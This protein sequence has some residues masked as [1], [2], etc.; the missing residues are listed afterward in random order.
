[1]EKLVY[2]K[3][4]YKHTAGDILVAFS[5]K[6]GYSPLI[7]HQNLTTGC[8]ILEWKTLPINFRSVLTLKSIGLARS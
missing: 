4:N 8:N 2:K 5:D 1:M 3:V 6:C 7:L